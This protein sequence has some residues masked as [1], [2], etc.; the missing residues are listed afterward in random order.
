[1]RLVPKSIAIISGMCKYTAPSWVRIK[2]LK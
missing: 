1:V 2:K